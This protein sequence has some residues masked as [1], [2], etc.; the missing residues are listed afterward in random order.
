VQQLS[1]HVSSPGGNV[2]SQMYHYPKGACHWYEVFMWS[3]EFAQ[4]RAEIDFVPAVRASCGWV[5]KSETHRL[6]M[7]FVPA[8]VM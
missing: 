8:V 5:W 7:D 2:I 3:E 1:P 4:S 6:E